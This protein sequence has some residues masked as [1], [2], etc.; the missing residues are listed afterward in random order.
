ADAIERLNNPN[1][2]D[3]PMRIA[4]NGSTK[5]LPRFMD[6]FY[7]AQ[8]K[9]IGK[10]RLGV[11]LLPVAGF[12]RY[13]LGIDDGGEVF[14]LEG[15]P[16]KATLEACGKA[17]CLGNRDSAIA[18]K[19]LIA[20]AGV[21]GHNLYEYGQTGNELQEISAKMLSGEGAVRKTIEE[22]LRK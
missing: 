11:V 5:M 8:K 12:L 9:G 21:M 4:L 1:I 14:A 16:K 2:P 22:Y 10:E 19:K 13:T 7:A 15:D 20:D 18:F 17:A 6:T 3:D